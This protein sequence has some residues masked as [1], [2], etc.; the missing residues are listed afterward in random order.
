[1]KLHF[2]TT[3]EVLPLISPLFFFC[4]GESRSEVRSGD[5]SRSDALLGRH[6]V[7]ENIR[8]PFREKYVH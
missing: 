7:E 5:S 8:Q 6:L 3:T 4:G 1:M 2:E